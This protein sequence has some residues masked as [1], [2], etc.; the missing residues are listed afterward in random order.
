MIQKTHK[1]Q[2]KNIHFI[3]KELEEQYS[4][5]KRIRTILNN[6]FKKYL[7]E[8]HEQPKKQRPAKTKEIII[9]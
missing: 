8:Q 3:I 6:R 1:C 7:A 4:F 9:C 2:S 5:Y